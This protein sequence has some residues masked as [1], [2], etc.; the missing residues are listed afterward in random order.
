VTLEP[1]DDLPER[2]RSLAGADFAT[3]PPGPTADR[4]AAAQEALDGLVPPGIPSS[5]VHGD[6][7]QGN[8][9]WQGTELTGTIDWDFAGVGHPGVD[10]GSVRC[11]A[12]LMHGQAAADEVLAGWE[13]AWGAQVQDAAHWDLVA[14]LS[15]PPDLN[16]WLPNFHA[17]GR[18]DLTLATVTERRDRFMDLALDQ[19]S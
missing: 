1:S 17:Q 10:L 2:E 3:A 6:L 14:A 16:D 8:T 7:W 5:F 18:G 13:S 11:D 19:L 15:S 12:A 4:Y 9:L